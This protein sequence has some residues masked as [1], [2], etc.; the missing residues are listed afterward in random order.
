MQVADLLNAALPGIEASDAEMA[1]QLS[2]KAAEI[3]LPYLGRAI[4]GKLKA[5]REGLER[6][7][8]L[9]LDLRTFSRLDEAEW[10]Q[11]DLE[12][13]IVVSLRFLQPLTCAHGV[14]VETAF[15]PVGSIWCSP[16]A[17]NQA[18]SNVIANAIQASEPGGLVTVGTSI[19]GAEAVIEVSDLGCGI[20]PEAMGKVFDPFFTTKPPGS[21]T[22]LGLSISHQ[23]VTGHHGRIEITSEPGKG[24]R[25]GIRIP[26]RHAQA[27]AGLGREPRE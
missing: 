23:I 27:A 4:P 21:G 18:V 1:R 17:L 10:K 26:L 16:S 24:T 14:R 6:V 25:V 13:G 11:C 20:P 12:V 2:E 8:Q 15:L 7:R 22:G 9:V 19:Q 3:D 5:N